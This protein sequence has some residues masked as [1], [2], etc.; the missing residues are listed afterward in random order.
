MTLLILILFIGGIFIFGMYKSGAFNQEVV[1]LS[2]KSQMNYTEIEN[3]WIKTKGMLVRTD[4]W[5]Q[6]ALYSKLFSHEQALRRRLLAPLEATF[7]ANQDRLD[8]L[9][10]YSLSLEVWN[11]MTLD[12]QSKGENNRQIAACFYAYQAL[13]PGSNDS[14]MQDSF[15]IKRLLDEMIVLKEPYAY[16][17]KGLMLKYGPDAV[18]PPNSKLA[19]QYLR[20]A[21]D[22]GISAAKNEVAQLIKYAQVSAAIPLPS[23]TPSEPWV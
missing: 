5:K 16:L 12:V 9:F 7:N 4:T 1:V 11:R 13:R 17:L 10:K 8:D 21:A 20:Q 14:V 18:S 6:D 19:E 22:L 23:N 2:D 15:G 3:E